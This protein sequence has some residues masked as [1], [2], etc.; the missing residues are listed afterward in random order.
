VYLSFYLSFMAEATFVSL[1]SGIMWALL[2]FTHSPITAAVVMA[3][4]TWFFL[5]ACWGIAL[6]FRCAW[7]G[8]GGKLRLRIH[9]HSK[10]K[11][12][13]N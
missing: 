7:S 9:V 13:L 12:T 6:V 1:V 2:V 4:G 3:F 5:S 8:F 10:S 11:C